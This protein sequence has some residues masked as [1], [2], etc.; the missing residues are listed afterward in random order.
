MALSAHAF[1]FTI[2]LAAD[3]SRTARIMS[4]SLSFLITLLTARLFIGHM[5]RE[6]SDRA[7]L[8]AFEKRYLPSLCQ[9]HIKVRILS[10]HCAALWAL[11]PVSISL[12]P[13]FLRLFVASQ[14]VVTYIYDRIGNSEPMFVLK[15]LAGCTL[16]SPS[17]P[18]AFGTFPLALI[19]ASVLFGMI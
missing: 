2:S 13:P 7:W 9:T 17:Q 8:S 11:G 10:P 1:L 6:V 12:L 18:L 14:D 5:K 16:S 19:P 15:R 3:A 4:M